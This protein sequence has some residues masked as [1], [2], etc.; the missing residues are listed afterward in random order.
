MSKFLGV[1]LVNGLG[2]ALFTIAVIVVLKVGVN[3]YQVKGLTDVV[4]TI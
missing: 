4:N 1:G 2:L 3:K